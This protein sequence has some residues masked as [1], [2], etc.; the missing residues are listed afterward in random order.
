M[1]PDD[2][3]RLGEPAE[4]EPHEK[5]AHLCRVEQAGVF[6]VMPRYGERL[7]QLHGGLCDLPGS[8]QMQLVQ[9]VQD[10]TALNAEFQGLGNE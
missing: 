5:M 10:S 1:H 2:Y 7:K 9:A 4:G 8:C 6:V 3:A